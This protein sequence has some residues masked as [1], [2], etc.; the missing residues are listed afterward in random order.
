MKSI[1]PP[2]PLYFISNP[3]RIVKEEISSV[4]QSP[5]LRALLSGKASIS[6]QENERE[7]ENPDRKAA[8]RYIRDSKLLRSK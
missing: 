5:Y 2:S 6:K 7:I 8:S 3:L 1:T 4:T